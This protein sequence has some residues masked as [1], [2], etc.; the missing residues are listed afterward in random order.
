LRA[1]TAEQRWQL[2]VALNGHVVDQIEE[3]EDKTMF[4]RLNLAHTVSLIR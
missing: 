3:L 2:D 4:V 1:W